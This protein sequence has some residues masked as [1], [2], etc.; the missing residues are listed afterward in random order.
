MHNR[1]RRACYAVAGAVAVST[2]LA[3]AGA[4]AASAS[5]AARSGPHPYATLQCN[6]FCFNLSSEAAGPDYIQN[7]FRGGPLVNLR[8]RSETASNEDFSAGFVGHLGQFCAND[9]G[10]GEI[11]STSYV[12]QNYPSYWDVFEANFAPNGE[13][14]GLCV[15]APGQI[16]GEPAVLEP[17]GN[18]DAATFW[19]GDRAHGLG[20]DCRFP[21]DYCPW[22]NAS[23][24][25]TTHPLALTVNMSSRH[26]SRQLLVKRENLNLGQITDTQQFELTFGPV[27]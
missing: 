2:T 22:V 5:T 15:G 14:S 26:P 8:Y 19:V 10:N 27:P 13:Q 17:C 9:G 20:G 21:G 12:C 1:F 25:Y 7:A 3:L 4:G 6:F 24:T 11:P 23:D 18:P 16:S